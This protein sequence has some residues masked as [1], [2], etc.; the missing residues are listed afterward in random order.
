M[1][2]LIANPLVPL[3]AERRE[4]IALIHRP[5]KSVWGRTPDRKEI[6]AA[7]VTAEHWKTVAGYGNRIK[8]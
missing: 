7:R 5:E 1:S 2:C 8:L 6:G 4:L 3:G